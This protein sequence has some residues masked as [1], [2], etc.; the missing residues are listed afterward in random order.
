MATHFPPYDI[1][2]AKD[3]NRGFDVDVVEAAFSAVSVKVSVSF[4]PWSRILKSIETGRV[5]GMISCAD[6]PERRDLSL[7]SDPISKASSAFMVR[8]DYD[9]RPLSTFADVKGMRVL[10]VK[11]YAY[12]DNL[13]NAGIDP[14]LV[15]SNE[16]VFR[17]LA[18]RRGD[19]VVV[20]KENAQYLNKIMK[21]DQTFRYFEIADLPSLSFHVCFSKARPGS[22]LLKQK[23]NEGLELIRRSGA[24]DRIHDKYR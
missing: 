10:A 4:S 3:G 1:E 7:L 12:V 16:A 5:E 13:R 9:G 22:E 17:M 20:G 8:S 19:V 14:L 18:K 2:G 15:K 11:G 24:Y 6:T 21:R 23:F